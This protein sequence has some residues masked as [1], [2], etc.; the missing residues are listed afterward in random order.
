MAHMYFESRRRHAAGGPPIFAV[1]LQCVPSHR[2]WPAVRGVRCFPAGNTADPPPDVVAAPAP[3]VPTVGSGP[4]STTAPP[5]PATILFSPPRLRPWAGGTHTHGQLVSFFACIFCLALSPFAQCA[6]RVVQCARGGQPPRRLVP[7]ASPWGAVRGRRRG[8]H[9]AT[10]TAR[11][12]G[13]RGSVEVVWPGGGCSGAG[14][15]DAAARAPG[16]H[17]AD[18]SV[19]VPSR[20]GLGSGASPSSPDPLSPPPF[21]S[22]LRCRDWGPPT[23]PPARPPANDPPRPRVQPP[24][25]PAAA[26]APR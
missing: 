21:P 24:P 11:G 20:T 2:E 25:L 12:R 14:T 26:P 10:A 23:A 13:A 8:S 5:L 16:N 3:T 22:P 15:R 4:L 18:A 1:S 7:H 17:V 9:T 19:H 6:L